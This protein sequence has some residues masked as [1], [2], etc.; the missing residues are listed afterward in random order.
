MTT[1]NKKRINLIKARKQRKLTVRAVAKQLHISKSTYNN[2]ELG[3]RK[4]RRRIMFAICNYYNKPMTL[5]FAGE[6]LES[7]KIGKATKGG[8]DD[9]E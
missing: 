8:V 3:K 9:V 7:F 5:L 1:I 4:P 6:P 2:Y